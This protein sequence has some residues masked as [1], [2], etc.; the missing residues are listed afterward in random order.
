MDNELEFIKKSL[1]SFDNKLDKLKNDFSVSFSKIELLLEKLANFEQR[2]DDSSKRI[3]KRIDSNE[4]RLNNI[5]YNQNS[6]GCNA[7]TSFVAMR[8][9]QL[10]HYD[11]II[12]DFNTRL[13]DNEKALRDLQDIPNKVLFRVVTSLI[14]AGILGMTT[15]YFTEHE[16]HRIMQEVR[17]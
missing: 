5:E 6:K 7:L 17:K 16:Y 9:E 13:K 14:V 15:Y 1:L 4:S 8:Q 10:K 2:M 12:D 11:G 3:H